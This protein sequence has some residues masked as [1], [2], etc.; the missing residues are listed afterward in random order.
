MMIKS[1]VV[2]F[3]RTLLRGDFEENDRYERK[4]DEEGWD[5]WPSLLSAIFFLAVDKRFGGRRDD[6]AIIHFVADLRA[7]VG[8]DGPVIEAAAAEALIR[9][10]LD[11][12][13][14]FSVDPAAMGT[15][16][17]LVVNKILAAENITD[18]E[19]DG[20]LAKAKE[21]AESQPGH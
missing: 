2:E 8:D 13:V 20:L 21:I 4:L 12:S 1:D 9:A 17:T 11:S 16:Q 6:A 3:A 19:L 15:I 7:E 5:G 18:D 14:E 10:V